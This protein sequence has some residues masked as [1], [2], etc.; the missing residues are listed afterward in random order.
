MEYDIGHP[1]LQSTERSTERALY[2]SQHCFLKSANEPQAGEH[3]PEAAEKPP[4]PL[5]ALARLLFKAS[6]QPAPE[7]KHEST[8]GKREVIALASS[9]DVRTAVLAPGLQYTLP[10]GSFD[11]VVDTFGLCSCNNPV[12][13]LREIAKVRL[14][15]GWTAV[16]A[17]TSYRVHARHLLACTR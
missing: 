5:K 16:V 7:T 1:C 15:P 9:D 10:S 2:L 3:S 12:V 11:C 6:Q 4:G 17:L 13:A 8:A 14:A